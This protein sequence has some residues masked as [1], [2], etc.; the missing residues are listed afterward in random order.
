MRALSFAVVS[1]I[2]FAAT[3]QSQQAPAY[4]PLGAPVR[5]TVTQPQG[6]ALPQS[7]TDSLLI[8]RGD[9]VALTV[10][11]EPDQSQTVR[12]TDS[13][14]IPL[15]MGGSVKIAG[16][17]P[18]QASAAVAE[19]LKQANIL[20]NPRV[21]IL[22]Q[23]YSTQGASVIGQVVRPGVVPINTPR[24]V[25]DVI[26]LAGGL[27]TVADR[28]VTIQRGSNPAIRITVFISNDPNIALDGNY[29]M[30]YPGDTVVVPRG[31]IVYVLG[32]VGRAGG[33]VMQNEGQMTAL[34]AVSIASGV[35]NDAA[36]AHTRLLR[37]VNGKYVESQL[38]LKNME[39][40]KVPDVQLMADDV[41]YVPFSYGR[42]ILLGAGS[43]LPAAA[44]AAIYQ[45]P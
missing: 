26:A 36:Q 22:V 2:F 32:D 42:H 8:S 31:G 11:G 27:D 29:A 4:A 44:S 17:T 40:G 5:S 14:D 35:P 24:R 41:I 6:S 12:V 7:G 34:Q 30:V 38:D 23:E 33:Y 20:L 16:L 39:K 1:S 10:Y 18:E 13:G 37:K 43:I 19:H 28:H 3:M 15:L 21:S 45:A 9:L 25:I